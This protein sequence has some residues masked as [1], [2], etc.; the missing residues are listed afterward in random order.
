MPGHEEW[1]AEALVSFES[2]SSGKMSLAIAGGLPRA[3]YHGGRLA[4][5]IVFFCSSRIAGIAVLRQVVKGPH[6]SSWAAR[7]HVWVHLAR[8]LPDETPHKPYT[9]VATLS[10]SQHQDE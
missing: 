6:I 5:S 1:A 3:G 4:S 7:L 10:T 2:S 9:W 8:H